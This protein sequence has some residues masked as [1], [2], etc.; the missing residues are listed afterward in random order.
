M[1]TYMHPHRRRAKPETVLKKGPAP[2]T[3]N[4]KLNGDLNPCERAALELLEENIKT[5]LNGSNAKIRDFYLRDEWKR[6]AEEFQG[7]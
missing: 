1:H 7:I 2:A 5:L 6:C 4:G 3:D